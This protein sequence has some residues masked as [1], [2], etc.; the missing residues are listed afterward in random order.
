MIAECVF[1]SKGLGFFIL[2]PIKSLHLRRGGRFLRCRCGVVGLGC[3]I[4]FNGAISRNGI[5][6]DVGLTV[7]YS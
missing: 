2:R 3:V 1:V 6:G 7:R 4:S 5:V